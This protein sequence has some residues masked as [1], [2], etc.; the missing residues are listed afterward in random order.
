MPSGPATATG[1]GR[2]QYWSGLSFLTERALSAEVE[3]LDLPFLRQKGAG[4]Y[5]STWASH[6]DYLNDLLSFMLHAINYD[7]QYGADVETRGDWLVTDD[8]LVDAVDRS[9]YH[10]LMTLCRMPLFK[11]QLIMVA[12]AHRNDGIRG[13]IANNYAGA[14]EPWMKIYEET[15]AARGYQLRP[16]ITMREFTNLLA[17]V[18]EGLAVRHLGDPERGHRR[19]RPDREPRGQGGPR[20]H[21]GVPGAHRQPIRSD[22]A[23]DVRTTGEN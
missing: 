20:D 7:P 13:A 6:D 14:L 17:A 23:R 16:G 19:P 15:L 9:S 18:T 3:E 10:E 21:G 1:D 4:P 22:I 12:T 2:K 11:L 8:S 5:R